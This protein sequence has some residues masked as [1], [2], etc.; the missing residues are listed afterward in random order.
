MSFQTTRP[1]VTKR[2]QSPVVP[3]TPQVITEAQMVQE[4]GG[5]ANPPQRTQEGR[6]QR[7][8][9]HSCCGPWGHSGEERGE[10]AGG[11]ACWSE[12]AER[13]S[14]PKLR[15]SPAAGLTSAPAP[16]KAGG[17]SHPPWRG[18]VGTHQPPPPPHCPPT[19]Q[20][21][22]V[23]DAPHRQGPPGS[24]PASPVP[25]GTSRLC[26]QCTTGISFLLRAPRGQGA[27][28][29]LAQGASDKHVGLASEPPPM[30]PN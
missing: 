14:Q 13:R 4:G 16:G 17:R 5:G 23:P 11:L 7:G 6:G 24:A 20:T 12:K 1:K 19:S 26:G 9:H 3:S 30:T 21:L 18:P 2:T 8:A 22:L 29:S 28:S 27:A 15:C 10:E 25:H